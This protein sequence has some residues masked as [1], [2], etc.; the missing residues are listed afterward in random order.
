MNIAKALV[1]A[2]LLLLGLTGYQAMQ[3]RETLRLE[4]LEFTGLPGS[5][6]LNLVV[7]AV[8]GLVGG[9]QYWGNFSPIRLADN[10]RPIHL[11]PLRPEFMAFTHRG[12]V[13]SSLPHIRAAAS[14]PTIR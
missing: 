14:V 3:Y 12:E 9:V 1:I 13:L 2:S 4:Q 7:A 10:P 8:I 6:L 5:L 11:R